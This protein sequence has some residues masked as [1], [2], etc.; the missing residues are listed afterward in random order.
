MF[1]S[2]CAAMAEIRVV[3]V[4]R[5]GVGKSSLGNTLLGRDEFPRD[6]RLKPWTPTCQWAD[7]CLDWINLH[8][9]ITAECSALSVDQRI[10]RKFKRG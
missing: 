1:L 5:T 8:V 3:L 2:L 10:S 6:S 9:S 4:G 7:V